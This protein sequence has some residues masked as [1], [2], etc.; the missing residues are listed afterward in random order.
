[1]T[2]LDRLR[3]Q[4]MGVNEAAQAATE[5]AFLRADLLKVARIAKTGGFESILAVPSVRRMLKAVG[6]EIR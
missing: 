2:N 4:V 6:E 5:M 3:R 1:M